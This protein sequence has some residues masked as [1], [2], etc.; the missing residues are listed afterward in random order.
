MPP[1]DQKNQRILEFVSMIVTHGFPGEPEGG[2]IGGGMA[3]L[4]CHPAGAPDAI[5]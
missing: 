3:G 1:N 4:R 5:A 2:T